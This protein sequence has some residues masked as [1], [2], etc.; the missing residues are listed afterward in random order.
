VLIPSNLE[1]GKT[2]TTATY[3]GKLL[4]VDGNYDDVNR[5]CSELIGDSLT[6]DWGFVNVNLRPYYAEGSKTIG[7]EIAEQLGWRLPK[8]VVIPIA[9]GALLVKVDKAFRELIELG[10][11]E[12]TAYTIFG[13]QAAGCSPVYQAFQAGQDVVHPVKPDTIAKSLAIGN[14]ADGPYALDVIRRTHGAIGSVTDP[15]LVD[16]I[17]KLAR[18][19]GVFAETAGGVVV[20]TLE[21]LLAQGLLDPTAETVI[22]NTGDGLKTLDAVIESVGSTATIA[23]RVS[24]VREALA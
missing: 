11:V 9:S 13:A 15:E 18:T 1:D 6:N 21:Q 22:L 12:N 16:G 3:D 5:L 24:E 2:V 19:E 7:Y 20:A 23:P 17:R 10:L 4:A 8:Q 14:P